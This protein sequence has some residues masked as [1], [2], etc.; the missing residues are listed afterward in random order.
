M[1]KRVEERRER[2]GRGGRGKEGKKEEEE[3]EEE[4]KKILTWV[5]KAPTD[6]DVGA[7]AIV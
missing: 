3:E 4:E 1:R 5:E 6:S 2:G 7:W